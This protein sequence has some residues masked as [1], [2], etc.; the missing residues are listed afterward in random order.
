MTIK[1][2]QDILSISD[3]N[4]HPEDKD[5]LLV[6]SFT[7]LSELEINEMNVKDYNKLCRK[8]D[9][10][11]QSEMNRLQNG[12]PKNYIKVNGTV[13]RLNYDIKRTK[14]NTGRIINVAKYSDNIFGNLH[15]I[16]ASVAQPLR[17]S[18]K[19]FR[20]VPL[21]VDKYMNDAIAEDMLNAK[22]DHAYHTAAFFCAL[23][24]NSIQSL[25]PYFLKEMEQ[26]M[27][28]AEALKT[29]DTIQSSLEGFE[30]PT[31]CKTY[32]LNPNNI[33]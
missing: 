10:A 27:P 17:W 33:A 19:K 21:K 9:K 16:M 8:V 23:F 6:Q 24:K 14:Q 26:K 22:F 12:K 3:A 5:V 32:S 13:Y 30:L 31:W 2:F 28:R 29:L 20:F 15:K 4:I 7:G 18:W 11:F 1:Q 25:Q